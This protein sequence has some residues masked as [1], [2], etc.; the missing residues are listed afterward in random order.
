M[1]KNQKRDN[2]TNLE[3]LKNGQIPNNKLK[4]KSSCN[5]DR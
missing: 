4:M 5:K 3:N 1:I 2:M